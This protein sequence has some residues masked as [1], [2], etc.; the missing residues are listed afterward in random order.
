M[1]EELF[2]KIKKIKKTDPFLITITVYE[3]KK[4]SSDKLDTFL[5]VNNFQFNEFDGTKAMI[6]KLIDDAKKRKK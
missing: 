3:K 5:L 4:N 2:K 6:C 1:H